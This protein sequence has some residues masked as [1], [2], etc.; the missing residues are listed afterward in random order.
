MSAL[1]LPLLTF[2]VCILNNFRFIEKMP[3]KIKKKKMQRVVPLYSPP[4][5][6]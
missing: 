1:S 3:K 6:S 4:S 2:L 5:L